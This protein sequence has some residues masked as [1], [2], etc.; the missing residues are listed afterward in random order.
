MKLE[1]IEYLTLQGTDVT[2]R[3]LKHVGRM[4]GLRFL[5]LESTKISDGG[6][7]RLRNLVRLQHLNL[8]AFGVDRAEFGAGDGALVIAA[9]LPALE[10]LRLRHTRV[11]DDGMESIALSPCPNRSPI[12]PSPALRSLTRDYHTCK[13]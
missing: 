10:T 7:L 5:N 6:I 9:G 3:Q 2:D 4:I 12:L 13:H 8:S 1:D 11:T